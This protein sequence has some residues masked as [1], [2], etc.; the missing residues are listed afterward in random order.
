MLR[1]ELE[2]QDT[3]GGCCNWPEL[4][5]APLVLWPKPTKIFCWEVRAR[6][7]LTQDVLLSGDA[8]WLYPREG[9]YSI[10]DKKRQKRRR[11]RA[12][13]ICAESHLLKT[14]QPSCLDELINTPKFTKGL[15]AFQVSIAH[16]GQT[17]KYCL[18]WEVSEHLPYLYVLMPQFDLTPW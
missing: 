4:L 15:W 10:C 11:N 17:T 5:G 12:Q 14:G 7:V 13:K 8:V 9:S 16:V 6:L 18:H 2:S 1:G 3:P